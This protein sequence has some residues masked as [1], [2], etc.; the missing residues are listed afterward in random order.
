[1]KQV[2]LGILDEIKKAM[3]DRMA[4]KLSPKSAD[5][6]EPSSDPLKP[7]ESEESAHEEPGFEM[8]K[9]EVEGDLDQSKLSPEEMAQ[10]KSLYEKMMG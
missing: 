1:M 9:V 5:N 4:D 7:G 3:D 10:L 6:S 8:T 2:Q